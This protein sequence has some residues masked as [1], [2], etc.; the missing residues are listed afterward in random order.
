MCKGD[1]MEF[2][3]ESD[4][5]LGLTVDAVKERVMEHDKRAFKNLSYLDMLYDEGDKAIRH[6]VYLIF[7]EMGDCAYV[8]KCASSHFVDRLGS[9]FGMSPNYKSTFLSKLTDTLHNKPKGFEDYVVAAKKAREYRYM[10]VN[11]T[12]KGRDTID[13]LEKLFMLVFRPELNRL[14]K[15]MTCRYLT[16]KEVFELSLY[17]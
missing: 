6:G 17:R 1:D 10:I 16:G 12:G 4:C 15:K 13:R 2:K 9:H 3:I 14:P 7:D 5:L 8:G 11:A